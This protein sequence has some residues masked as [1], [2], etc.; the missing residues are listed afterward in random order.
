[1]RDLFLIISSKGQSM[2]DLPLQSPPPIAVET[3]DF[4]TFRFYELISLCFC[5][6]IIYRTL[7][8]TQTNDQIYNFKSDTISTYP[9]SSFEANSHPCSA[10]GSSCCSL[11]RSGIQEIEI[12]NLFASGAVFLI[13]LASFLFGGLGDVVSQFR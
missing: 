12:P 6:M 13:S 10:T 11:Q 5:D 8:S 2:S 3:R 1:M 9:G 7:I 4:V